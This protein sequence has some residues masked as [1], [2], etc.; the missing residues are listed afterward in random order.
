MLLTRR[1]LLAGAAA[2]P[3]GLAWP[4]C[5][6]H[7]A[8]A[9]RVLVLL[10][11]NGGNDGLNTVVPYADPAYRRIRP[12]LALPRDQVL[13][14][15]ERLGLH[16]ALAPLLPAWGQ[17][18]FAIALGVGYPR[19]NRSHF[20]SIEI[21]NAGTAAEEG[22]Q[23]GW[24]HRVIQESG[25]RTPADFAPQGI[26]LG[27]PEGPLAGAGLSPVVMRDPRQVS[28]ALRLLNGT[29]SGTAAAVNPALAHI[30]ATRARMQ[31]AAGGLA[32]T[33][34]KAPQ[35]AVDFPKTDLG[36]QLER[37]AQ[38]IAAAA[39]ASVIKLQHSGYDT[40]ARQAGRHAE[41]L[42]ELAGGLAAFRAALITA[43]AWQRTLVATYSEFGRR[44]AENASAG[45]DHG[46]AAPQLLLGGR[47][48]GGFLGGQPSL[49]DLEGG[50]LKPQLDFRRVYATLAQD[51]L[52]LAPAPVS[53][54]PQAPL[55]IV[56]PI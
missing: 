20:R 11:L 55:A 16:P 54:G 42:A 5:R 3:L 32:E 50:D 37:A 31:A 13:Q 41:L 34:A 22:L 12:Q 14:I 47:L 18:D 40:H 10:E 7:A 33:L 48:R 26:V 30:L 28:E 36:R 39:P 43:G 52:G 1:S 44:A 46:S 56:A 9:P 15:D 21:W 23:E 19:P 2:L 25:V 45:T 8:P 49:D 4:L 51:W 38:L 53:L 35:L 27:G 6:A 24:L 17:R 29:T